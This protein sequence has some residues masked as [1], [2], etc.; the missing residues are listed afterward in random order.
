MATALLKNCKGIDQREGWSGN[1]QFAF[2]DAD[3]VFIEAMGTVRTRPVLRQVAN[4]AP[5]A[6]G[7][8]VTG[9]RL[10]T[11]YTGALP[12]GIGTLIQYDQLI[13]GSTPI[14][15]LAAEAFDFSPEFGAQPVLLVRTASGNELHWLRPPATT[16]IKVPFTLG[17]DIIR[18]ANHIV[19]PDPLTGKFHY[20]STVNGPADFSSEEGTA[21]FELAAQFSTGS[22]QISGFGMHRNLLAVFYADSCQLWVMDEQPANVLHQQTLSGPGCPYPGSVVNIRGDAMFLGADAFGN[23]STNTVVGQADFA[24][25]GDRI[26]GLTTVPAGVVPKAVWWEKESLMLCAVGNTVFVWSYFPETKADAWSRWTFPVSVDDIAELNG[27][28]YIRSGR[29][30]YQLVDGDRDDGQTADLAWFYRV[31]QYGFGQYAGRSK[32]FTQLTCQQSGQATWTPVIDDELKPRSAVVV[33]T[34]AAA[35]RRRLGGRGYR[36]GFE[37]RGSAAHRFFGGILE[38]DIGDV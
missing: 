36:I 11:A 21:G 14:E 34:N 38:A 33:G 2:E 30:V 29:A 17:N 4:L 12:V 31:R 8:Y 32:Q 10:R 7:L 23:L 25:V 18:I 24:D 19:A 37:V 1:D 22:R 27:N 28:V 20:C 9:G 35:Q 16:Y 3:N 15:L 6:V 5:S 26:R 13:G